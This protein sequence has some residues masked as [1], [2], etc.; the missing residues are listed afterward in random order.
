MT[1]STG[2]PAAFAASDCTRDAICVPVQISQ[3]LAVQCTVALSGSIVACARNGSSNDA[4][5]FSPVASALAISPDRK[6]TR[7]NSS[8]SQISY[9][10]FCLKKKKQQELNAPRN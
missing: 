3:E 9:A 2:R 8:H 5:N 1:F 4:S 6:S 7:L 10:V